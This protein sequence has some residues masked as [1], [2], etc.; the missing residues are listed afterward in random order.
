MSNL[1]IYKASAGSGKTFKLTEEFLKLALTGDFRRILAVT[2]TNKATAE[3]KTRIVEQLSLLSSGGE[4]P[5]LSALVKETGTGEAKVREKAREVLNDIL[6]GFSRFSV[7]T[8]DS[9]FQ[10]IIRAFARE[11]SLESGFELEVDNMPVL[12]R[13]I[14]RMFLEATENRELLGWLIDFAGAKMSEGAS[15]NFQNDVK[16]LGHCIFSE[17]Y[18]QFS[19]R[20]ADKLSDR[21]FMDSYRE[22]LFAIKS[23]FEKKMK[24]KGDRALGIIEIKGL[25][26]ADFLYGRNGVAGYFVN[27]SKGKKYAPHSRALAALDEPENWHSKSSS[28]K[29]E[30]TGAFNDGL[31]DCLREA[32]E[33]YRQEYPSYVTAHLVLNYIYTL[34][35]MTDLASHARDYA[36]ENNVFLLSDVPSLLSGIIGGNDSPFVYEKTGSFYKHFMIDEFQDTSRV[37]WNNFSPLILNSLSE[38]K[39]NV[40][41][42]DVKQSIYRWRNGD[43]KILAREV[44]QQFS[45]FSPRIEPLKVNRRSCPNIVEFNNRFFGIASSLME[46]QFMSECE[47]AHLSADFASQTGEMITGAYTG[48]EQHM[49]ED[50]GGKQG[51]VSVQF[52]DAPRGSSWRERVNSG[53]PEL[54]ERL[55]AKGYHL[56]DIAVL[57]RNNS[58]G[59]EVAS[60][61]LEWGAGCEK[62]DISGRDSSKTEGERKR[63]DFISD[64]FLLLNE[65]V[66][67]RFLTAVLSYLDNP[68]DSVSKALMVNEYYRYIREAD[69]SLDLHRLFSSASSGSTDEWEAFLPSGFTRERQRLRQMPLYE[70]TEELISLFGLD[71]LQGEIPYL[72]AFQDAVLRFSSREAAGIHS[73]LRWWEE[74]GHKES[75]SGS[76][77][78]DA[79]RIMTIHKAKGLQFRVVLLP[80]CDWYTDH[81]PNHENIVWCR[82]AGEPFNRLELVPVRYK[83]EMAS[84][85]FAGEYFAEKMQVYVDNL[86]LLYVAFTRAQEELHLFAPS[87]SREKIKKEGIKKVPDLIL[88]TT[89]DSG[90][91]KREDPPKGFTVGAFSEA[92]E[93][94]AEKTED[95]LMLSSYPSASYHGKLRLRLAGEGFFK[96]EGEK[97]ESVNTGKIMHEA[98]R[99]I[100]TAADIDRAVN[101]LYIDGL[102][103]LARS[104]E[105]PRKIRELVANPDVAGWF[106]GSRKVK[107]EA[108]ILLSGGG[109]KRPDRVMIDGDEAIVA[110]YK[111]GTRK[112]SSHFSQVRDYMRQLSRM[113]YRSVKGYIWYALLGETHQVKLNGED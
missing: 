109:T 79:V 13:A 75:V 84:S 10:R 8:I 61:L 54:I 80:Y 19:G 107:T 38:E 51:C 91:M 42:G 66:S 6:Q 32:V 48:H 72:T 110:D 55:I 99:H 86:N 78:Q 112:H 73:F 113:G 83:K 25:A 5:Y 106:D 16:N 41:V 59:R 17:N 90:D 2:F 20:L 7:G 93:R 28:L 82:P 47:G 53:L 27:L 77:S 37:Q 81:N 71:Q 108:E 97:R 88:R 15:W 74:N 85:L 49:S 98:F 9:F 69:D 22:S 111:F 104:K 39:R 62:P 60:T 56:K 31:N 23:G 3:M 14:D 95:E 68:S 65:S 34:G 44:Q 50:C 35:I 76:D 105:L 11:I 24:E 29:A 4:S 64:E 30:I 43:W 26:V 96:G 101:R 94:E 100:E 12:E 67:V 36:S 70:L 103:N 89:E 92:G 63:L 45:P 58:D 21:K 18:Q 40:L 102:I 1:I 52:V 33:T 57:V 87:P 46:N